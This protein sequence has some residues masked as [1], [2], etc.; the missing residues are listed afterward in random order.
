MPLRGRSNSPTA[1]GGWEIQPLQSSCSYRA[2]Y[3]RVC[4]AGRGL[5]AVALRA[6]R[7]VYGYE[8]RL[9]ASVHQIKI[10]F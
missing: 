2:A 3:G 8:V 5:S 7:T 1:C 4:P 10:E 9:T 6:C